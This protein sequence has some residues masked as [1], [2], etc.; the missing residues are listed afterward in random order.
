MALMPPVPKHTRRW[1]LFSLGTLSI[2]ALTLAFWLT[3]RP[4]PE[5]EIERSVRVPDVVAT[6]PIEPASENAMA[7]E[8]ECV[9]VRDLLENTII[10]NSYAGNDPKGVIVLQSLSEDT[11]WLRKLFKSRLKEQRPG[12]T[13]EIVQE[14]LDINSNPQNVSSNCMKR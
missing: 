8:D 9:L 12:I 2:L 1:L 6:D 14:F 10:P 3:R 7:S 4:Q 11:I 5:P 13:P